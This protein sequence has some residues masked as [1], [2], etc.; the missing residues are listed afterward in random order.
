MYY[1]VVISVKKAEKLVLQEAKSFGNEKISFLNSLHRVLIR[2]IKADRDYPPFDRSTMDG[3]AISFDAYKKGI[4][5]FKI[6]ATLSAGQKPK[7]ITDSNECVKIMTGAALPASCDTVIPVEDLMIKDNIAIVSTNNVE[8]GQFVHK[9]GVDKKKSEVVLR[10]GIVITPEV[11]PVLASVGKAYISVAKL[12]K[13]V[14]I[15]TGDELVNVDQKPNEYQI[16]RSNDYAIWTVISL[17]GIKADVVHLKDN[18][19]K[20][21]DNISEYLKN[22][23]LII[24]SGGVSKGDFDYVYKVLLDLKV[25]KIFHGIAQKPGKPMWFGKYKKTTV[26]ALPGNPV[27]S[28]MCANRY[29]LPYLSKCLGF[30]RKPTI[31]TAVLEFDIPANPK[32]TLFTQASLETDNSG[33]LLAIPIVHHGSGDFMSMVG[34]DAFVELPP[35]T[36]PYKK[37]SACKIWQIKNIL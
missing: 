9:K 21:K 7:E 37:G 30:N 24:I 8:K 5:E 16:R 18:E 22:Y 19:H 14:I 27:S 3:I 35:K 6:A 17:Y 25:K 32:L 23:D 1:E 31:D 12:P 10:K 20:L 2:P 33:R 29:I 28:F 4:H 36:K 13:V 11:T 26:F 34:A 15:S